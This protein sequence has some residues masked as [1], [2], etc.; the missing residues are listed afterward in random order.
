MPKTATHV[1]LKLS[2]F[3]V[4]LIWTQFGFGQSFFGKVN[5]CDTLKTP[6]YQAIYKVVGDKDSVIGQT[7]F[8]GTFKAKL[9]P[10]T[11]YKIIAS[12]S[13]YT[14]SII[15]IK[16]DSK[17][18]PDKNNAT[19]CLR[20]DGMRLMGYV[21]NATEEIPINKAVL[22]LKNIVNKT[23][24]Q[25]STG[26]DGYYNFKLDYEANY[27]LKIDKYSPGI[28]NAFQDTSFY[29]STIGFNLPLD[30]KLDIKLG[31]STEVVRPREKYQKKVVEKQ[32]IVDAT[33]TIAKVEAPGVEQKE[34]S[35]LPAPTLE[36]SAKE[37]KTKR[38]SVE[39]VAKKQ[40]EA[41]KARQEAQAKRA[42]DSAS[43]SIAK[44]DSLL[45]ASNLAKENL[46]QKIKVEKEAQAK[47][48]A[49][50]LATAIAKKDSLLKSSALAKENLKQRI[51][52]EK[53]A[54]AKR[55]TDSLAT[56]MAKKDSLL[57]ASASTKENAKQKIIAE[58]EAQAKREM[59]SVLA[60]AKKDSLL[61][62]S[63]MAKEKLKQR[64]K[65]EKEAQADSL[66]MAMAKKDSLQKAS[67]L[68][69]EKIRKKIKE[70]KE[71]QL[72]KEADSVKA[73]I[74]K[75]DSLLTASNFAKENA[76]QKLKA[77]KEA[78]AKHE[79]DSITVL[80]EKKELEAKNRAALERKKR[81]ED[82]LALAAKEQME[83]KT[84]L[85]KATKPVQTENKYYSYSTTPGKIVLKGVVLDGSNQR[86]LA[87]VKISIHPLNSIFSTEAQTDQNGYFEAE[88]DS[89]KMYIMSLYHSDYKRSK[90]FVDLT[91]ERNK[92]FGLQDILLTENDVEINRDMPA[93]L[94]LKNKCD[95]TENGL[96][97]LNAVSVLIKADPTFTIKL[98]G[99]AAGDE[100]FTK[101]LAISRSQVAAQY[102]LNSGISI[103]QIKLV[104]VSESKHRSNCGAGKPCTI[105]DYNKDRAVIYL[106]TK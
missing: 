97:E 52:A 41:E 33:N 28:M 106:I 5:K 39:A 79:L 30:F 45:R 96:E 99:L 43:A 31:K 38:D 58:K 61:K 91:N 100:Y 103:S 85:A 69:K 23:E 20:K 101:A 12:Y 34:E 36:T 10:S 37:M 32:P 57:R 29:I 68:A 19:F 51:K 89:G 62:A 56:A 25:I 72:K 93:V 1:L 74:A 65:A 71:A 22:I 11:S 59:D 102:L 87:S 7:Y 44:K 55:E 17:G 90:Q 8:D 78:Q 4:L 98:I 60:M 18:N 83:A 67:T 76:K 104:S 86:K 81:T 63:A 48:E 15:I 3:F 82:S 21:I 9:K 46:N 77:E 92:E 75:K 88:V 13:G 64:I 66:S 49:D 35:H 26:I 70:E 40:A 73:S 53:E 54:N 2:A 80:N 14:D 24:T 94:F 42:M 6:I 50:S 105:D 95:L 16:T 27:Q 84:L 47:R